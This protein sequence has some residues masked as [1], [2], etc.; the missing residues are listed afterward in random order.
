MNRCV[1]ESSV[2]SGASPAIV[3]VGSAPQGRRGPS[4]PPAHPNVRRRI[5]NHES[6]GVGA[7]LIRLE[8][9]VGFGFGAR[10]IVSHT[11]D[12]IRV[13][14]RAMSAPSSRAA[15]RATILR[16]GRRAPST[17]RA[18]R[19]CRHRPSDSDGDS[20]SSALRSSPSFHRVSEAAADE[21]FL[22]VT[23]QNY[24]FRPR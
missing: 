5:A 22:G 24:G 16:N 15:R 20:H 12:P 10:C 17:P 23:F 6:G 14:S 13:R 18:A 7:Q 3:H 8:D 1:G 11:A 2:K 4:L 9:A 21:H 19:Q